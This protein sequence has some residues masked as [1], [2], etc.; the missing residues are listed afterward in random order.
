MHETSPALRQ[1]TSPDTDH[2]VSGWRRGVATAAA[3]LAVGSVVACQPGQPAGPVKPP[4]AEASPTHY[5]A[6]DIAAGTD[7]HDA[8]GGR[9]C[10]TI[11][12]TAHDITPDQ[13]RDGWVGVRVSDTTRGLPRF[14]SGCR[15]DFDHDGEMW[16]AA[17]DTSPA[18]D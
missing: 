5:P 8:P 14:G 13:E 4:T 3:G 16:V 2:R 11:H 6:V 10:D 12:A 17:A 9:V 18:A 15:E 1:P 7:F